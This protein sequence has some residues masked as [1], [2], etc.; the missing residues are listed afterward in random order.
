MIHI[1]PFQFKVYISR[2][3]LA[4]GK[5]SNTNKIVIYLTEIKFQLNKLHF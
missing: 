2:E 5:M 4:L 1:D 3:E